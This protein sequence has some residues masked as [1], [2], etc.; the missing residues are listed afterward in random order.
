MLTSRHDAGFPD[1]GTADVHAALEPM[2]SPS[3][4]VCPFAHHGLDS[5]LI[6]RCPGY[7]AVALTFQGLGA[8]ESLGERETCGHLGTQ[9]TARGY[10][11][12]CRHPGGVPIAVEA[13]GRGA[14]RSRSGGVGRIV[15]R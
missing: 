10:V 15:A 12:A 6:S 5:A 13:V 11:S 14:R 8:G 3:S 2:S 4:P 1:D 7:T 9:R